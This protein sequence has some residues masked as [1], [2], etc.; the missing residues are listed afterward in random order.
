MK[1]TLSEKW[2]IKSILINQLNRE[3]EFHIPA[4]WEPFQIYPVKAGDY[5]LWVR[6]KKSISKEL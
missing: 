3:K 2:I 4:G 1:I 5:Q 6:R